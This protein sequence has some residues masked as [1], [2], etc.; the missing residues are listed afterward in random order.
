MTRII[1][2][3]V[4][5]ISLFWSLWQPYPS[6]D[7]VVVICDV[8]Q[9]DATILIYGSFQ[10]LIDGG[11]TPEGVLKCLGKNLPIWDRKIEMVVATHGDADHIGGLPEVIARYNVDTVLA[12]FGTKDTDLAREL[13]IQVVE[14]DTK[15]EL[16]LISSSFLHEFKVDHKF[17]MKIVS[18]PEESNLITAANK[19]NTETILSDTIGTNQTDLSASKNTENNGSI[20]LYAYF[21]RFSILL[22]GDLECPGEI[23]MI[24]RGVTRPVNVLKVGHH[25]SKSSSCLE[26]LEETLPE[27]AIISLGE[28]NRFGHPA[29]EV[30]RNLVAKNSQIWRTDQRGMIKITSDGLKYWIKTEFSGLVD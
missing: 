5:I 21:N 11:P 19:A 12:N 8:G 4:A 29:P 15:G 7:L 1:V 17:S 22:T 16:E 3:V 6:K 20:V 25:G 18:P 14:L 23:A 27:N 9:G 30:L 10:V 2:V 28:N 26:F 24:R 13:L